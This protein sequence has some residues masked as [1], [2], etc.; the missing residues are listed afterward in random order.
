MK[1]NK[2]LTFTVFLLD[3]QKKKRAAPTTIDHRL[4]SLPEESFYT[5]NWNIETKLVNVYNLFGLDRDLSV[6]YEL[7]CYNTDY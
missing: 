7:R 3:Y 5:E 2:L 1:E 6:I 4:F